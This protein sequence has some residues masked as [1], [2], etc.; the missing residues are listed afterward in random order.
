M[1]KKTINKYTIVAIFLFT[2][3]VVFWIAA[4]ITRG[5]IINNYFI[6]DSADTYMDY[7]NM[8]ANIPGLSPYQYN[9]NYPALPF[10]FWRVMFRIIP[11]YPEQTQ[12]KFLRDTME[13]QLGFIIY[14]IICIILLVELIRYQVKGTQKD[15]IVMVGAIMLSGPIMFTIERGNIILLAFLFTLLFITLYDSESKRK[16]YIAYFC[17]ALAAAIKIYPAFFGILVLSKKR[18]KETIDLLLIGIALFIIPFLFFNGSIDFQ[19]MIKGIFISSENTLCLGFGYSDSFSNFI[20]IC[21]AIAGGYI[22][23]I[24]LV[25]YLIPLFICAIIYIGNK[26]IWKRSFSVVLFMIW[27]PSFSYTYTLIF[28]IIPLLELLKEKIDKK[29]LMYLLLLLL[30]QVLYFLPPIKSV[31]NLI[32]GVFDFQLTWG[33]LIINISLIILAVI[34]ALEGIVNLYI[35]IIRLRKTSLSN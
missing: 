14:M 11:F 2:F 35:K 24:S 18:Y 5:N 23:D 1:R 7:F 21:A 28:L 8:L 17:L 31:N 33:M 27:L 19:T 6:P 25:Y 20:R 29:N 32:E 4:L 15:K 22:Q 16:R 34:L 30:T 3:T 9:A 26:S 12:G 13:A 10:V